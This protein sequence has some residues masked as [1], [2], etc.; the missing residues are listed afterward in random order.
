[1]E[2]NKIKIEKY[3]TTA[4]WTEC[5]P[6]QF[7]TFLSHSYPWWSQS[8]KSPQKESRINASRKFWPKRHNRIYEPIVYRVRLLILDLDRSFCARF[9]SIVSSAADTKENRHMISLSHNFPDSNK[10]LFTKNTHFLYVRTHTYT[11]TY[12]NTKRAKFMNHTKCSEWTRYVMRRQI[13]IRLGDITRNTV[14]CCCCYELSP[15]IEI[16]DHLNRTNTKC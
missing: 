5:T 11:H 7:N 1:M 3:V 14:R 16:I 10:S 12:T 4:I 13:S 9:I 2:W 8:I 15:K 6:H